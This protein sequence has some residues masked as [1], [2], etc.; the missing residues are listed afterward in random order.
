[1]IREIQEDEFALFFELMA[2]VEWGK[3]FDFKNL[4]YTSSV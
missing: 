1:M 4:N 2:E 3:L